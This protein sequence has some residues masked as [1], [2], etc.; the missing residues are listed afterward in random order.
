[1]CFPRRACLGRY[2]GTKAM[3]RAAYRAARLA[4]QRGG[5][6]PDPRLTGLPWKASLIVCYERDAIDHLTIGA[7]AKLASTRLI[8]ELLAE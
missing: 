6:K 5:G 3:W 8:E 2:N 1:M 4:A 7:P